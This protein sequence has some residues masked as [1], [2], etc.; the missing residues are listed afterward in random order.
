MIDNWTKLLGLRTRLQQSDPSEV[1]D[2]YDPPLKEQWSGD[3]R[4][5]TPTGEV[6]VTVPSDDEEQEEKQEEKELQLSRRKLLM[7]ANPF[8]SKPS[9]QVLGPLWVSNLASQGRQRPGP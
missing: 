4:I 6:T 5:K 1:L 8:R 7:C 2:F 9:W 3:R